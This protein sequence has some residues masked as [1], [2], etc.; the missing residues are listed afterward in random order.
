LSI[1][2]LFALTDNVPFESA[3]A[4]AAF[5]LLYFIDV[6]DFKSAASLSFYLAAI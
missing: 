5:I 1:L 3:R 2:Y 4:L 6:S